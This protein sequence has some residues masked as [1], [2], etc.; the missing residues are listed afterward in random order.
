MS[1]PS[2]CSDLL[3]YVIY[4]SCPHLRPSKPQVLRLGLSTF[5]PNPSYSF[6]STQRSAF[7]EQSV[8]DNIQLTKSVSMHLEY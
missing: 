4:L 8:Q 2:A 6:P 1:Y 3:Y 5:H 7:L